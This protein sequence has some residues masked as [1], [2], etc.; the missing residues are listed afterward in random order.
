MRLLQNFSNYLNKKRNFENSFWMT[1]WR[2]YLENDDF[3][4]IPCNSFMLCF[5]KALKILSWNKII[6]LV[7][8]LNKQYIHFFKCFNFFKL[9]I[10][11]FK[12]VYIQF[13]PQK[14]LNINRSQLY[15]KLQQITIWGYHL[16]ELQKDDICCIQFFSD[17]VLLHNQ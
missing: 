13:G 3:V 7:N 10:Y 6:C 5:K 15:L 8:K 17:Q 4:N 2:T 12:L 16:V 14:N 11:F 9:Y 1:K